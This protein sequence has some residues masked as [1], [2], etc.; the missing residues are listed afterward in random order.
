MPKSIPAHCSYCVK[1]DYWFDAATDKWHARVT[2]TEHR[3][4]RQYGGA[5][6]QEIESGR[7][8]SWH[9]FIAQVRRHVAKELYS[10]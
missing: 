1:V 7:N 2:H 10:I 8:V 3:A 4:N 9:A 5:S 6:V